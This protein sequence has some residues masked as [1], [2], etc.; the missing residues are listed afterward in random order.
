MRSGFEL[1]SY[2]LEGLAGE[3]KAIPFG[4][5]SHKRSLRRTSVTLRRMSLRGRSIS[6]RGNCDK[7]ITP[8][9]AS[10]YDFDTQEKQAL[11][12]LKIL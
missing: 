3:V 10:G 6:I 8:D 11:L 5:R 4:V 9:N 2:G 1:I 7:T 12:D